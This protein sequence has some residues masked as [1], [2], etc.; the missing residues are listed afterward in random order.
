MANHTTGAQRRNARMEKIFDDYK[1]RVEESRVTD[2][3]WHAHHTEH[4]MSKRYAGCPHC[5]R[6]AA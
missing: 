2:P 5:A 6:M 3:V 1:R 4:L